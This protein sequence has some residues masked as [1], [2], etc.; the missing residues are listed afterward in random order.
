MKI[1]TISVGRTYNTLSYT[2]Q[3]FDMMADLEP[4]ED[5]EQAMEALADLLHS[6]ACRVMQARGIRLLA[7][8]NGTLDL[9]PSSPIQDDDE[10]IPL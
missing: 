10:E 8:P 6:T 2:S 4:F 9:A 3:R 1:T 5:I 7:E